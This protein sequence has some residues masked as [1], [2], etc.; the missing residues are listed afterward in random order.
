MPGERVKFARAIYI[1]GQSGRTVPCCR[2]QNPQWD[3]LKENEPY[4]I[5]RAIIFLGDNRDGSR[6]SR[7]FGPIKERCGPGLVALLAPNKLATPNQ[8][9]ILRLTL[10]SSQKI[11]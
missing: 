2:Y 6:D 4:Q 5:R 1:D 9:T 7:D 11:F 10:N 3:I 8:F